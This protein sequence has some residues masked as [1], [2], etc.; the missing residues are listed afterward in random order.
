MNHT[1]KR[2]YSTL[3]LLIVFVCFSLGFQS[4]SAL[5][6]IGGKDQ[7]YM[8]GLINQTR[9]NMGSA[10]H[11]FKA[12]ADKGYDMAQFSLGEVYYY[13]KGVD[14]DYSEALSWYMLAADQ[15][16]VA[17]QL[18]I[19]A[20]HAKGR[21]TKQDYVEANKWFFRA[22]DKGNAFAQFNVGAAYDH[23]LGIKTDH[24]EAFKWFLR[25]AENG[26]AQ[27][28]YIVG[29]K[30]AEGQGIRQDSVKAYFWINKA[31]DQEHPLAIA[32]RDEMAKTLTPEQMSAAGGNV[33]ASSSDSGSSP[34][35]D[36]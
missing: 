35:S 29:T 9:G 26:I 2:N 32:A 21:G 7:T 12:S 14:Q 16:N 11:F 25:A 27:A 10:I 18:A 15:G 31:A 34:E 1:M 22:A 23:G 17:A 28:Q 33:T 3:L 36:Q 30:Y 5:A 19:G 4:A 6:G 8:Q 20:M 13:G 24:A